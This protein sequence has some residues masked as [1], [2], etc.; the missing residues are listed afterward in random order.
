MLAFGDIEET[1][2]GMFEMFDIDSDGTISRGE[3]KKVISD[4]AVIFEDKT[5]GGQSE[6]VFSEMDENR[7]ERVT[8]EEF[9]KSIKEGNRYG[10]DQCSPLSL[11]VEC[12]G[13][14]L[15]GREVHSVATPALFCHKEPA[16]AYKALERVFA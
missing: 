8:R 7:D 15:I 1:L 10:Q 14:T 3:M 9:V 6:A 11:V 16:Q 2:G 12:R 13:L 5:E 4:M